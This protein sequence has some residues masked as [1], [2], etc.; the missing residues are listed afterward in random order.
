MPILHN[1]SDTLLGTVTGDSILG[2]STDLFHKFYKIAYDQK[3]CPYHFFDVEVVEKLANTLLFV[4]VS[5]GK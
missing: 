3:S 1:A 2:N 5:V 4:V